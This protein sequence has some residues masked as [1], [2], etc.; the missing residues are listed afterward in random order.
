MKSNGQ[1]F[2]SRIG[3]GTFGRDYQ[4]EDRSLVSG[5]F[6]L[7]L[8]KSKIGQIVKL[9]LCGNGEEDVEG[10]GGEEDLLG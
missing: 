6:R 7:L 3:E 1:P 4:R 2:S 10:L 9:A 8:A 5:L